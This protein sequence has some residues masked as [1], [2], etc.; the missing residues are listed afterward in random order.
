MREIF[1]VN[2]AVTTL[3]GSRAS[4]VLRSFEDGRA[5]KAWMDV[6]NSELKVYL[7]APVHLGPNE[8]VTLGQ[9][10]TTLGI[11]SFGHSMHPTGLQGD[12]LEI[13]RPGIIIPQ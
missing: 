2:R 5:A 12:L 11:Q 13:V 8:V 7:Q 10:L 1:V 4:L 6:V 9:A 3:A